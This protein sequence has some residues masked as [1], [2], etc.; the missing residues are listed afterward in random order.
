MDLVV[1][2]L[3]LYL[4]MQ[5]VWV[6]SLAGERRAHVPHSQSNQNIWQ[7]QCCNKFN[8]DLKW[9]TLKKKKKKKPDVALNPALLRMAGGSRADASA[10]VCFHILEN[11]EGHL[12]D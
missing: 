8:K 7:K 3:R 11:G 12:H 2:C 4:P 5:G 9:F 6:P 1:Q 10:F